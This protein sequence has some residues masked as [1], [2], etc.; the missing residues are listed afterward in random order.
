[1][2]LFCSLVSSFRQLVVGI[3]IIVSGTEYIMVT[4]LCL[5]HT[6]RLQIYF[7]VEFYIIT[8]GVAF[9]AVS[10]YICEL[11]N[12]ELYCYIYCCHGTDLCQYC[13][14]YVAYDLKSFLEKKEVKEYKLFSRHHKLHNA[15]CGAQSAPFGIVH[16]TTLKSTRKRTHSSSW[17]GLL[18]RR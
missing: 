12:C 10:C 16:T 13:P 2:I 1:M 14:C 17:W 6:L 7:P 5:S 9:Y 18:T 11:W 15:F 3:I 4:G 8:L